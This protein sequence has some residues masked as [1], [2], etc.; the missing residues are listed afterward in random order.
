MTNELERLQKVIAQSGV[1]SRRKA[2]TLITAGKVKV[3]GKVVTELGTKVS[4]EDQIEV[5]GV[6]LHRE[7]HVYFLFYKPR[8][9]ISS[10]K[11]E[12]DR[13]VVNDFFHDIQ[14]R[15]FP[16]GR[17]DYD[18]SGALIMTNDGDF[19]NVLMHPKHGIRKVY[20]AKLKGIPTQEELKQLKRG[21]RSEKDLL[22][23]VRFD[24]LSTD[25][26]K[27]TSIVELV[28]EEGKNRHIRRMMEAL[29][30]PVMKLKREKYGSLTLDGLQ[31]GSYRSLTT[32]EIKQLR[33][34][35]IN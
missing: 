10:V 11:D 27:N 14:Q 17:L 15:I 30:Y 9:V 21:V 35:A 23:A 6:P 22:K 29:G 2:E 5:E 18:S 4:R 24:I 25:R 32:E 13:T 1:T 26:K 33:K 34:L 8:G 12:K 7:K 16:V 20:V 31:P 19:A 3:N 28:L